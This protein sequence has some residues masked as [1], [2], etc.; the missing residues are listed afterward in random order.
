MRVSPA[1]DGLAVA[2]DVRLANVR[3]GPLLADLAE[4]GFLD[5]RVDFD[6]AL[7]TRGASA[8]DLV[9]A[10]DGEGRFGIERAV[11]KGLEGRPRLE[12]L[13]ALLALG[14]EPGQPLRIAAADGTIELQDGVATN[15]DLVA[16]TTNL[17]LSGAGEVDLVNRRVPRYR[18]TPEA[19][20]ALAGVAPLQRV[21]VPLLIEGPFDRLRVRPD[22][23]AVGSGAVEEVERALE[24][25]GEKARQGDLEGAAES[26]IDEGL[27]G[28]LEKFGI[29]P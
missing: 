16:T 28:A 3:S 26:I 8:H 17:R 9:A 25:A 11:L 29:R 7:E 6:F 2:Q 5:G 21:L 20:G 24:S 4:V 27:G 14:G 19:T 22:P 13:R 10:A 15:R 18:L 1:G 12:A 23:E